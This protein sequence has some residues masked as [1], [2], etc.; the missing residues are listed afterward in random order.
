MANA[1]SRIPLSGSSFY[2]QIKVAATATPG[3]T[4]H[5]TGS[6]STQIDV[7]TI[8]C[9][10]TDTTPRKLTIEWGGT[11]SPDDLLEVTIPAESGDVLVIAGKPL[12][13]TGAATATVRAFAASANVL[14]I[15]GYV[16][17]VT[18]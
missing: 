9:N 7:I 16:D 8:F 1:V 14:N 6:G 10:N 3:T 5:V 18:P 4:I 2:R 11:T 15:S 12:S 13:G 17:R